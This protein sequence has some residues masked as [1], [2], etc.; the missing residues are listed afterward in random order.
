M[1]LDLGDI[2]VGMAK[3]T[4]QVLI[5]EPDRG[6][7][8]FDLGPRL[9]M[10]M[11]DVGATEVVQPG[12]RLSYRLLLSGDEVELEDLR[13]ALPL[14]PDYKWVSVRESSPRIGRLGSRR[15]VSL[16]GGLLGVLLA[17]I[18]VFLRTATRNAILIMSGC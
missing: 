8:I 1:N 14:E 4:W 5:A 6:G 10:N 15:E 18:A 17:G 11:Q 16:L 13:G 7:S 2:E 12:S 3:L 9:L